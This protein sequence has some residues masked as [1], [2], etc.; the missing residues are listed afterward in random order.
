MKFIKLSES[1]GFFWGGKKRYTK[2]PIPSRSELLINGS[3]QTINPDNFDAYDLFMT[4]AE[5]YAVIQLRASLLAS[6]VW[7]HYKSG[8][9]GKKEE[10]LNSDYVNFLENPNPL[11]KGNQYLMALEQAY[12]VHGSTFEYPVK[13]HS[14][15]LIP[16]AIHIMPNKDMTIETTGK[17]YKQTKVDEIIKEFKYCKD[18]IGVDEIIYRHLP[19]SNNPIIGES[20]LKPLYMELSNIRSA[21]QF[22]NVIMTKRGAL[23]LLVNQ[24]SDSVGSI[25]LESDERESMEKQFKDSYGIE[26]DQMQTV[27]TGANMRYEAMSYPTKDL[28]LFEEVNENFNRIID[29]YGMNVNLFSKTKG[30]TFENLSQGLKQ[31]YQSTIIPRAEEVAMNKTEEMGMDGKTQ[32]LEL[33]YSKIPVLQ[34]NEKEKS[35]ILNNKAN[36]TQTLI[37]SGY[38]L[39]E[40]KDIISFD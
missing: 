25:S 17:W 28:M 14:L 6:G 19:N 10:V 1:F 4:T 9:D 20:P 23:G 38:S 22:R 21:K 29:T 34:E 15:E 31:A 12:C 30:S 36:A 40:V 3:P 13:A 18:T 2:T 37:N 8:K 24:S 5:V 27:I 32:W 16:S 26:D 33:D 39:D 11:M 35:E 7:K